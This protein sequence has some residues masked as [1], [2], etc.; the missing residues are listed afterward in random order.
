MFVEGSQ[1][2]WMQRSKSRWIPLIECP[3]GVPLYLFHWELLDFMRLTFRWLFSRDSVSVLAEVFISSQE[4]KFLLSLQ[5]KQNHDNFI[6]SS[7]SCH[8]PI[9]RKKKRLGSAE[10]NP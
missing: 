10:R 9:Y 6:Y 8:I 7:Q 1:P 2:D 4:K 5:T 3:K